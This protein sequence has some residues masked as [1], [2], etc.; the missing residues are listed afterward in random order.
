M[1]NGRPVTNDKIYDLMGRVE[2]K[3]DSVRLELKQDIVNSVATMGQ[4][5]G[6]LEA[7]FDNLEAGRLTRS[8]Q[9]ITALQIE[10]QKFKGESETSEGKIS[11]KIAVI[12]AIAGGIFIVGSEVLL[13]WLARR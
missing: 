6:R 11:T 12:W 8:E 9:A 13:N 10:L 5:Q 4:N 1:A 3:V 2:S 7:K